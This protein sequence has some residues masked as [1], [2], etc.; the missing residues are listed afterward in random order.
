MNS[1]WDDIL[2]GGLVLAMLGA[3]LTIVLGA[4]GFIAL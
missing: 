3:T 4:Y 2:E 1:K